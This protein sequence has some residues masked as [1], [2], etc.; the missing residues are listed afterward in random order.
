MDWG[1]WFASNVLVG[2]FAPLVVIWI[3][4]FARML[5]HGQWTIDYFAPYRDGQLGFVVLG[6]VA[7]ALAEIVKYAVKHPQLWEL[8]T[9]LVLMVPAF[10]G[11]L[12]AAV[13]SLV[14]VQRPNPAPPTVWAWMRHYLAFSTS[15]GLCVLVL[16][17]AAFVHSATS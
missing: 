14:P 5:A 16:L 8:L 4:H 12:V 1:G 2:A 7:G 9:C 10:F 17:S 11:A 3:G 15:V 6:W 13:G